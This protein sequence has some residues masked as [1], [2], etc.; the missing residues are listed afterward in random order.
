MT[1]RSA[2]RAGRPLTPTPGK[3]PGTHS[4]SGWV[5]PRAIV[6][7]E[8]FGQLKN[9]ITSLGIELGAFRPLPPGR[10]VVRTSVRVWVDPRAIVWLEGLGQLK[11]PMTL[12]GIEFAAFRPL[13]PGR[14]VVRISVRGW[15]D[16]RAIVWLEGLG[17][18]K[19]AIPHWESNSGPSAL[20]PQEDSWYAFLLESEWTPGP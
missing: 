15:V 16:P 12:L 18:L 19:N 6:R 2:L 9:A 17:Q 7:L 8:G 13:P 10:F 20:Y 4:V 11:N 1:V 5:D 3:I 14:F